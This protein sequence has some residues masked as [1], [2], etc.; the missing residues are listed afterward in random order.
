MPTSDSPKTS[1]ETSAQTPRSNTQCLATA[2]VNG[3]GLH[4]GH[5]AEHLVGHDLIL[6][7]PDGHE[8]VA[9]ERLAAR[10]RGEAAARRRSAAAGGG[11]L[12]RRSAARLLRR[13]AAAAA[14]RHL[15]RDGASEV[16]LLRRHGRAGEWPRV[17]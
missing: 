9:V 5:A 6:A 15:L 11:G 2:L 17:L 8:V 1:R 13:G 10:H 14:L 12:R 4:R 16:V 3:Q 7:G